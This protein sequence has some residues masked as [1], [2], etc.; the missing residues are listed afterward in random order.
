MTLSN[1]MGGKFLVFNIKLILKTKNYSEYDYFNIQC[2]EYSC[3]IGRSFPQK[4]K[5]IWFDLRTIIIFVTT[6]QQNW[7]YCRFV[8]LSL[9]VT[10]TGLI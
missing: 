1:W 2:G 3:N 5:F 10:V 9:T 6:T 7:N 8:N 4:P